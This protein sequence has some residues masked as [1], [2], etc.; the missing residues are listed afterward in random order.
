VDLPRIIL[1]LNF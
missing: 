1:L